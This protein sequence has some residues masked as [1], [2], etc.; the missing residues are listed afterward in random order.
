MIR[1]DVMQAFVDCFAEAGFKA[2]AF[3]PSYGL[4]EADAGRVADAAGR[5]HPARAGR[6][7]RAVGRRSRRPRAPAPLP[8]HRQL[9]QAGDRHGGRDP[10]R[11]RR[12][13][14]PTAASASS[15][16]AA[17]ASWPAISA[18]RNRPPPACRRR[19][20]RHRRHGLSVGR[21][22]LHRRPRQGHDHHQRPQ[23]LAAGHR[24]GGRA[25][26]R[27]QGRRHRRLRHHR[28]VGRGNAGGAGPL[29]R[30]RP[31]RA[32]PPARRHPRARPRDH[33]H[34]PGRRAG[35]AAHPAAHQLGQAQPHQGAQ[36]LSRPATSS[37]TTSPPDDGVRPRAAPRH[38]S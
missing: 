37:P 12:S 8:R 24:M 22:H 35:P 2:S 16:S 6:G 13:R 23:P 14:C 11:R 7:D 28:L 19:L 17:P 38:R 33:R 36:P 4:A 25:I 27:L 32:R 15:S 20:A 1:P 18:T 5:R 29:P 21:L 31:R 10:R 9:R 3:C 26:A 30:Q 34:H